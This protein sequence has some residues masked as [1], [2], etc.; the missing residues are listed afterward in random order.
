M[1]AAALFAVGAFRAVSVSSVF[2]I[3]DRLSEEGWH[4]AYHGEEKRGGL[5]RIFQVALET[6][7]KGP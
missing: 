5:K 2:A 1:E 3:S 7:V 6:I 4:Q